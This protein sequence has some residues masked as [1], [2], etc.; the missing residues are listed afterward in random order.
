MQISRVVEYRELLWPQTFFGTFRRLIRTTRRQKSIPP[1]PKSLG[2]YTI[3]SARDRY[4][5]A[6]YG[7]HRM[8]GPASCPETQKI[9]AF[10][11]VHPLKLDNCRFIKAYVNEALYRVSFSV[12]EPSTVSESVLQ[13]TN[14]SGTKLTFKLQFANINGRKHIWFYSI[15]NNSY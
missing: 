2:L 4:A 5:I 13:N 15:C 7:T 11:R 10:N 8:N 14:S 3:L 12:S 6:K 9:E 1:W